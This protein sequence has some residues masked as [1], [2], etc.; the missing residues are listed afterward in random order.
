LAK[1]ELLSYEIEDE[2][3]D[4][5]RFRFMKLRKYCVDDQFPTLT[6]ANFASQAD[7]DAIL[8]VKYDIDLI[9]RDPK[10][11]LDILDNCDI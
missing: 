8:N 6:R 1:L 11:D 10:L 9:H 2:N 3:I 5:Y 4:R 7:I